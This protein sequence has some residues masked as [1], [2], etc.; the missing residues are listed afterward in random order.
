MVPES[1]SNGPN[2]VAKL[3]GSRWVMPL[4]SVNGSSCA[5]LAARETPTEDPPRLLDP[6]LEDGLD[7]PQPDTIELH[8]CLC[9]ALG[10]PLPG[11]FTGEVLEDRA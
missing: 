1:A 2:R 11:S 5:R 9:G 3:V 7:Y 10:G 8:P 4:K 6:G